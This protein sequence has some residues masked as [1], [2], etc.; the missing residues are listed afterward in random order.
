VTVSGGAEV[1][2]AVEELDRVAGLDDSGGAQQEQVVGKEGE[3]WEMEVTFAPTWE[4][5]SP[6]WSA[7]ELGEVDGERGGGRRWRWRRRACGGDGSAPARLGA[8]VG[9]E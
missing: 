6:P 2:T 4:Q 3:A 1:A 7:E 8:W 9:E 5:G